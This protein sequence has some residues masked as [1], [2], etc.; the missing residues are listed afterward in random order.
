MKE[1]IITDH[2]CITVTKK[3][4]NIGNKFENQ[5]NWQLLKKD[6]KSKQKRD[7]GKLINLYFVVK[8]SFYCVYIFLILFLN[9]K[10]EEKNDWAH[11]EQV[12]FV[13][14]Q[15]VTNSIKLHLN[16]GVFLRSLIEEYLYVPENEPNIY[17]PS[18]ACIWNAAKIVAH[19]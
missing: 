19:F 16:L 14:K 2:L 12:H 5:K 10:Y 1:C 13:V 18:T 9:S 3:T 8:S 15:L 6:E 17:T 11:K 4:K 7:H